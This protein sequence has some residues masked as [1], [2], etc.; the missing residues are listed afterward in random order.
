MEKGASYITVKNSHFK[1]GVAHAVQLENTATGCLITG[2]D[3]DATVDNGIVHHTYDPYIRVD[4]GATRNTI[5][6]NTINTGGSMQAGTD[7]GEIYAIIVSG[8]G[9]TVSGN[10]ITDGTIRD[11]GSGNTVTPNTVN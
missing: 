2:N 4:A 8:D 7:G 3:I 6:G 9:N 5:T 10:T 1:R 11:T